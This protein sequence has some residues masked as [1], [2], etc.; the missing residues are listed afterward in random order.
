MKNFPIVVSGD[1]DGVAIEVPFLNIIE[2]AGYLEML[3]WAGNHKLAR[4]SVTVF[5][6]GVEISTLV[7]SN[8]QSIN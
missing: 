7:T 1:V 2:A 4:I 6:D 8:T 5:Q 3:S